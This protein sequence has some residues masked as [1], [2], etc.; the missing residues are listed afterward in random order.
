[1]TDQPRPGPPAM[2]PPDPRKYEPREVRY[3]VPGSRYYNEEAAFEL[4]DSLTGRNHLFALL[5]RPTRFML[6]HAVHVRFSQVFV[7]MWLTSAVAA[8]DQLE[9]RDLAGRTQSAAVLNTWAGVWGTA[10]GVGLVRGMIWY[11][12][13]G[14]WF[15]A[16]LYM[17]GVRRA[18]WEATGRVFAFLHFPA[19][20]AGFLYY[21]AASLTFDSFQDYLDSDDPIW[22]VLAFIP[23]G[24]VLYSSVIAY[25]SVRGVF[26][27]KRFWAIVWFL[28]LP[29]TLRLTVVVGLAIIAWM[30]AAA[31]K[32]DLDNPKNASTATMTVRYPGNWVPT[33]D[34]PET[35]PP[36]LVELVPTGHDAHVALEI[37]YYNPGVD[38]FADIES[39]I[40]GLD[41]QLLPDPE[42]L[43]R[44]G[45]F[46]GEGFAY[47][48]RNAD[49]DYTFRVFFTPLEH[50]AWLCARELIHADS[51]ESL[52]PG[53]A[54]VRANT[55]VRDPSRLT[56]DLG[57]AVWQEAQGVRFQ[58][59]LNWWNSRTFD[60]QRDENS[61][62]PFTLTAE[63]PQGSWFSAFTYTSE[64]GL[65]RELNVTLD[66]LG[67]TDR[68]IDEQPLDEWLG[69][70]GIGIE[71]IQP[72]PI[73]QTEGAPPGRERRIRVLITP[74]ADGTILEIRSVEYLDTEALTRPGFERIESTFGVDEP[75]PPR[76][77]DSDQPGG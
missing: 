10:I 70:K 53:L 19:T 45:P 41:F 75:A 65:R 42:P 12:L 47:A 30:M 39:W 6:A 27:A 23:V 77:P 51:A 68:L 1:M 55:T 62:P 7:I 18:P 50:D 57:R 74:R 24:V 46:E 5:F 34:E 16:R 36:T 61:P 20:F 66:N 48:A 28:F 29:L 26:N 17:C 3:R 40:Q 58:S 69:L 49:N 71:G 63:S 76:Q 21:V 73:H 31:P 37:M 25:A 67:V 8:I 4:K 52:E 9:F 44:W 11:W 64:Y 38:R 35:G 13:G 15:R 54:F 59:P 56:P 32:P 33:I 14:L 72:A 22:F 2:T 60:D 43:A